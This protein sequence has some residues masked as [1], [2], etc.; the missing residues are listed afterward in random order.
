MTIYITA[1]VM[2]FLI[3]QYLRYI[4]NR[5]VHD[6]YHDR[7]LDLDLDRDL[8]L[9]NSSRSKLEIPIKRPHMLSNLM[10]VVMFTISVITYKKFANE[11]SQMFNLEQDQSQE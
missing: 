11:E 2:F 1:I 3:C 5:N 7:D 10:T 4:R 6:L 9:W 8:T